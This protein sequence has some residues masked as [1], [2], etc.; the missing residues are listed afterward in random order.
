M[1]KL[2]NEKQNFEILAPTSL[3]E[4]N[5]D[6]ILELVKNIKVSEHYAVV[7]IA[8]GLSPMNLALVSAKP[9][10]EVT[11]SV[12]T[13][14]VKS[15]DPNGKIKAEAGDKIVTSRSD[16]ERSI[17]LP[18]P[19]GISLSNITATIQDNPHNRTVLAKNAVDFAGNPVKEIITIAFKLV[20]LNSIYAVIDKNIKPNDK[21]R[22]T[23]KGS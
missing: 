18:V 11:S 3:K 10:A 4:L 22:T 7:M 12:A 21:F 6:E 13:Y 15:N 23:I 2:T 5:F 9:D 1:I 20:P 16:I 17:H 8:Q 14:F 19:C